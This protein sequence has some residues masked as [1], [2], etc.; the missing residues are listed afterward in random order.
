MEIVVFLCCNAKG[1]KESS[2][3]WG[4]RVEKYLK[5]QILSAWGGAGPCGAGGAGAAVGP[6][7]GALAA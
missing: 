6:V 5:P 7:A 4:K 2:V 3:M 1:K